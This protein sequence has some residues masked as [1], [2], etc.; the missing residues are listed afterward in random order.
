MYTSQLY[1]ISVAVR[2]KSSQNLDLYQILRDEKNSLFVSC[3][4]KENA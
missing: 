4:S 3:N 2:E 1:T